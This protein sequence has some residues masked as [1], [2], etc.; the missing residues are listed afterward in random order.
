LTEWWQLLSLGAC[1]KVFEDNGDLENY[2]KYRGIF[3]EYMRLSLRRTIVQQTSERSATI[4]TE[5]SGMGMYPWG[6]YGN[7]AV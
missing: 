3:D 5:Q 6:N 2:M 7:G 4:Y 1:L